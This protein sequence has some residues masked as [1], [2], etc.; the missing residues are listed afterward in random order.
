[1]HER[2]QK[3]LA[4]LGIASRRK[5]EALIREGVVTI[6]GKVAQLGDK[7]TLGKDAIKVRG[8]LLQTAET[9]EPL[10]L[11]FNKPKGV[12]TTMSDPSG[13][14]TLSDYVSKLKVR[15]FPVGRMDYNSEGL[16]LLTND[17]AM[18]EKIQK[19]RSIPRV[20][21]IK[22]KGHPEPAA[23]SR[24][25]RGGRIG[26]HLVRPNSVKVVEE[27]ASKSFVEVVLTEQS[28]S[29]VKALFET[30]GFLVERVIRTSIGHI[31]LKGLK[32]GHF[33]Y[34]KKVQLEALI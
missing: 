14:P 18:A 8:K 6:N 3:I 4:Q 11:A 20:Y 27:L 24:V 21:H 31:T 22:V 13:R 32:P 10:Y 7:A 1:M 19:S 26:E 16:M 34:L 15:V 28:A 23:I 33:R 2:V 9:F 17:G 30:R 12:I 25:M 5:A 29:D